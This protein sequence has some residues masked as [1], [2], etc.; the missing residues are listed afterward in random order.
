MF[1][2]AKIESLNFYDFDV[3]FCLVLSKIKTN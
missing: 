1:F 2:T 3:D